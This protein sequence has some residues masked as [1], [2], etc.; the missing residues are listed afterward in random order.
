MKLTFIL[1]ALCGVL[2]ALPLAG[3]SD[4]GDAADYGYDM[5]STYTFYNS[6]GAMKSDLWL[7]PYV[8][9]VGDPMPFY[10]NSSQTF[11]I[12]YL[13]DLRNGDSEIYHPI[14]ELATDNAASY[15]NYGEAIA[16]GG[17]VE[18]D[19]AM[20]TGSTLIKAGKYY[21]FYT[22][23]K[24]ASPREVILRATSDD[25]ITWT[26]DRSFRMQASSNYN[27]DEFRDPYVFYDE[28]SG[29]Y[30]MVIAAIKDG[31]SVLAQY[32]SSDLDTW[33]ESEPFFYNKWGRFYECPD[34]FQ[35][36]GYWYLVYSD[37]DIT[38][39]VQFFYAS[40]LSELMNMGD[41]PEYP[42]RDEG[43]LE[44][45][46]FYAGKTASDGNN[47]YIWGWCA[48]REG[49]VSE[50]DSDWGGALVAHKVV[51]NADG[52]LGF[53]C[54]DA[55]KS[56][57]TVSS[58]V[59]PSGDDYTSVY[60]ADGSYSI[61]SG[62]TLHFPRLEYTN[63]IEFDAEVS[64]GESVFGISFVDCSD[65]DYDYRVYIEDRW[66]ALKFDKWSLDEAGEEQRDNINYFNFIHPDD[67]KYHITAVT[68]QSVCVVYINGQ[69]A[70][71]NRIYYMQRNPW[72]IF[73]SDGCVT[74]SNIS[75][76]TY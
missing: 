39:Q 19:P 69:Y 76:M 51:Q 54:P 49:N 52:T 13:E 15:T 59:T 29:L 7:K 5:Q 6:E 63:K 42:W 38:R 9:Y 16:C 27:Q 3:C 53:D 65:R 64:P 71:T 72:G 73:C 10:D 47:R 2:M 70:F 28:A 55:I 36:G 44:G 61:M 30:R 37:K 31:T 50:G 57:F 11:R 48:T 60:S 14:Y 1:H 25:G 40:S 68:D 62:S 23:H 41:D 26:K 66:D 58:A 74:V 75:V 32:V 8:G 35:M 24:S 18:D 43:K 46:S 12:L 56:K 33:V 22:G 17:A 34:V 20:G 67:G 4:D 21:T 45:T